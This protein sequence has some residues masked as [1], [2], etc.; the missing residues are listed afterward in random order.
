MREALGS[1]SDIGPL[2]VDYAKLFVGPY[3]LSAAPYGSVYLDGERKIM[4]VST[5]DVMRRYREA[6]LERAES[7]KDAPDH[8]SAEL[9][10]MYYLVF[11]EMQA[12]SDSE[13]QTAIGF[14][15][16]QKEFL[17]DH[18]TAWLPTFAGCI[19]EHAQNPF[20]PNLAKATEAFLENSRQLIS[21]FLE[22]I[23]LGPPK[24]LHGSFESI[25]GL[26][27]KYQTI[28]TR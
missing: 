3:T 17:D 10:F 12:L 6:G 28:D 9:E 26:V 22:S 19:K 4:G 13:V 2:K 8:V 7:F 5:L 15:Q 23:S 24:A 21:A 18:L 16:K 11:K 1:S 20:Y 14:I 25:A 27:T